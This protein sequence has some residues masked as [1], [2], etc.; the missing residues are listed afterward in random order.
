[1]ESNLQFRKSQNYELGIK[2]MLR[3]ITFLLICLELMFH[4]L[5]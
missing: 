2:K 3:G 1:M 4:L 5:R